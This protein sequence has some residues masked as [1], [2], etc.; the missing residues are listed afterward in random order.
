MYHRITTPLFYVNSRPHI[1]HLYSSLYADAITIWLKGKGL[2]AELL[3][4]TDEHGIKV[5]QSAIL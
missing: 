2:N 5:F 1:G 4:G 3:T